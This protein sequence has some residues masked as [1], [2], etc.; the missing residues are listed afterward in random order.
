LFVG[1]FHVRARKTFLPRILTI[2]VSIDK[3][4]RRALDYLSI[5][6]EDVS[7]RNSV[8]DH[9]NPHAVAAYRWASWAGRLRST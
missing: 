7:G 8:H 4:L 9:Y 6:R 5:L 1:Q 2:P 3:M